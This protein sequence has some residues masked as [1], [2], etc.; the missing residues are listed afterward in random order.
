VKN[1]Q[2]DPQSTPPQVP[3]GPLKPPG[4]PVQREAVA[5]FPP[6]GASVPQETVKPPPPP[7]T[8][9]T[10]TRNIPGTPP[11]SQNRPKLPPNKNTAGNKFAADKPPATDDTS[12][13]PPVPKKPNVVPSRP[14]PSA[15]TGSHQSV[16]EVPVP[17]PKPKN[18]ARRPGHHSVP[19][20]NL[21]DNPE[22]GGSVKPSAVKGN[23]AKPSPPRRPRGNEDNDENRVDFRAGLKPVPKPWEKL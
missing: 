1:E 10:A 5:L 20:F 14:K 3:R 11:T 8:R 21:P 22:D 7:P 2:P 17:V 15:P 23:Q 13:T 9:P 6:S 12:R 4:A 18:V 19:Q 16:P